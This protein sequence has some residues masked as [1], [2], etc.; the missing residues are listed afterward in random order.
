MFC[1]AFESETQMHFDMD[2]VDLICCLHSSTIS[3]VEDVEQP[4]AIIC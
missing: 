3:L 2:V 4:L 1:N